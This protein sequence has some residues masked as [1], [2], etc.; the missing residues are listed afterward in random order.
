MLPF[1]DFPIGLVEQFLSIVFENQNILHIIAALPA[2]N[3][4]QILVH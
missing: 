1:I 2:V 4:L 3:D